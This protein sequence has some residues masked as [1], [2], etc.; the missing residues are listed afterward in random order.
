[1][2]D[3][4][5]GTAERR[6]TRFRT[7]QTRFENRIGWEDCAKERTNPP[8]AL[9]PDPD[10]SRPSERA[11]TEG[12]ASA[13]GAAIAAEVAA[14]NEDAVNGARIGIIL[15]Q[16]SSTTMCKCHH[17]ISTLVVICIETNNKSNLNRFCRGCLACSKVLDTKGYHV[18][19]RFHR[20]PTDTASDRRSL[21]F[22][23]LATET[24]GVPHIE[25]TP[26]DIIT[27][28]FTFVCFVH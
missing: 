8:D 21:E 13:L 12:I 6:S 1:M 5:R 14:V 10:H 16:R 17:R 18:L 9:A 15:R 11:G 19:R 20:P 7:L 2:G 22:R 25:H 24:R 27:N 28:L 3:Q 4:A 23:D 26:F